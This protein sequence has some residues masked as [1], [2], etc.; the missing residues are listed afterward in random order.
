MKS[1]ASPRGNIGVTFFPAEN[2]CK[3][4]CVT[5]DTILPVQRGVRP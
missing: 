3:C 4:M 2:P 1:V 5:T